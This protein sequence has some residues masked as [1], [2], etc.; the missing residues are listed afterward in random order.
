M[1]VIYKKTFHL[2]KST[3]ISIFT[4]GM[5]MGEDLLRTN[6]TSFTTKFPTAL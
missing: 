2:N 4:K 1:E 6:S 3:E 5:K